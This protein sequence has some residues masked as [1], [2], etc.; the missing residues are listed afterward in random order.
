[1]STTYNIAIVVGSLRKD[2]LNRKLANALIKLAPAS[3]KLSIVEIADLPHFNQDLEDKPS[4]AVIDFKQSIKSAH[5]V[6]FVTPEY[7][8][9]IPGVLKNAI[10][11][12]TRPYGQSAWGGKPGA[13]ISASPGALGGFGANHHLRQVLIGVDVAAMPQPE[14]YVSKATKL[15]D[16]A[17]ALTDDTTAELL[18]KFLAAFLQWIEHHIER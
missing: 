18:K 3:L 17:G 12:G 7:N 10:D 13:V 2:S 8:R 14:V 15:F 9:S 6:L 4:Q 11:V 1:M 16:D 5:A